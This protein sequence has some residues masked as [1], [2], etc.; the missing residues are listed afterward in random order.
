MCE[1]HAT[2]YR[3]KRFPRNERGKIRFE[4]TRLA[5]TECCCMATSSG[6]DFSRM[7]DS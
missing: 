3:V 7:V 1:H 5:Q 2:D 6:Q 4:E